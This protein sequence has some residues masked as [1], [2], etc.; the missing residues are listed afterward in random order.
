MR[1]AAWIV[2]CSGALLSAGPAPGQDLVAY[3]VAET[4]VL[5]EACLTA[6]LDCLMTSIF[7]HFMD[8]FTSRDWPLVTRL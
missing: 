3:S 6:G 8:D 5:S 1:T 2:A 4:Q 7:D